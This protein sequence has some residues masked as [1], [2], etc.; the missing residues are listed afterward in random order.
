MNLATTQ[1]SDFHLPVKIGGDAALLK[2]LIKI[3][4]EVGHLDSDFIEKQT[5]GLESMLEKA[6]DTDWDTI[7]QDLGLSR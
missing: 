6:R 1:L 5:T 2:G 4:D 3:H 7:V